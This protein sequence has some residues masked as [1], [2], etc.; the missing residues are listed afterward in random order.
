VIIL[1]KI[2]SQKEKRDLYESVI[3]I[4][5]EFRRSFIKDDIP[6]N[7]TFKEIEQ[8]GFFLVRFP[9]LE[10]CGDLS[11]FFIEKKPYNCIYIN[12]RQNLGRQYLSV[13]HECFHAITGTG[14]GLSYISENGT[15]PDEY[16]ADSFAGCIL[17]PEKL[18][19][20]Y[21]S[22]CNINVEY[23]KYTDIIKMQNYFQVGYSAMLTRIIQLF[24]QYSNKLGNR[25]A[26][27]KNNENS[28]E[29]LLNFTNEV[30]GDL[31][32]I[33]PTNDIFI[34][35]TFLDNIEFNLK[36]KRISNEKAF[37]MLNLINGIK[38]GD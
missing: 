7:D 10:N 6:I 15:N 18:V 34:P 1:E 4:A 22:Q 24:P 5:V 25:Y 30:N 8:L 16:K 14:K 38:N 37:E 31:K 35:E 28:R 29:K 27:A 11:G 36:N 21:I 3:P 23:I 17:M 12:S 9:A 32:L 26:I 20:N 2:L 33:R 13:W 19:Y